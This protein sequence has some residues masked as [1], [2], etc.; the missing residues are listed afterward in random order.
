MFGLIKN[1]TQ[2]VSMVV[3]MA[4]MLAY[5]CPYVNP[6]VFSWLTFFGTAF[7]WLLLLN[8]ILCV[9]WAIHKKRFAL[10]HVLILAFGWQHISGFI[11]FDFEKD[12]VPE[13][14][15]VI[16]TH[17]LGAI[18]R[19]K[20]VTD[21]IRE[22]TI[23]DYARFLQ[24]NGDPDILCTQE[25]GGKFY[26][27]LAAKMGYSHS[28]NLQKGTVILSRYP[29]KGGGEIPFGQT[30][31]SSLWVE[32]NVEGKTIRVYNVHM[33]SN[34]VTK[35]TEKVLEDGEFD[36]ARTWSE[37]GRVLGR[38]GAS[39]SVRAEQAQRLREHINAC[40]HP[41]IVCGDF[42]DTPNSY[43]YSLLSTG[44]NDPFRQKSLGIG[45]TFAGVLPMLRI[46]YILTEKI[47]HTYSYRTVHSEFSDH[48]PV[49]LIFGF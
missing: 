11:G 25:T 46:D 10:Y 8:L 16:A 24:A 31:N 12:H 34:K 49:V 20:K 22:K 30:A 5:I 45:T 43:V 41:V 38:V 28:F 29:I 14:S 36:D 48:Y 18:F 17:N 9:L 40:K 1:V 27:A 42:N 13:K 39:T 35:D 32:I 3:I 6:A 33:Q 15:M 47:F 23:S 37:I 21:E 4:T 7:P 44:F 2:L 26:R 19:G